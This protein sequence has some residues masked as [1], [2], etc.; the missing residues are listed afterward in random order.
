MRVHRQ[1][2]QDDEYLAADEMLLEEEVMKNSWAL[3]DKNFLKQWEIKKN[4]RIE[5]P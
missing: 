1:E 4:Q 2:H 5:E 3:E